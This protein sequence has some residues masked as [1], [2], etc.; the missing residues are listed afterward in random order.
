MLKFPN[1]ST[2]DL[3]P[4]LPNWQNDQQP[5]LQSVDLALGVLVR[6]RGAAHVDAQHRPAVDGTS[7]HMAVEED[8]LRATVSIVLTI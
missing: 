7:Q 3:Q 4:Y 2:H 8:N 5:Y 6:V 1:N